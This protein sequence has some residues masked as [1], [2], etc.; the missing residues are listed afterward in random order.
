METPRVSFSKSSP[1]ASGGHIAKV[2]QT[3]HVATV[4][5]LKTL[6]AGLSELVFGRSSQQTN[7][8]TSNH[9]G[10]SY[11]PFVG[12]ETDSIKHMSRFSGDSIENF[13]ASLSETLAKMETIP[14]TQSEFGIMTL[15]P[16]F[17][18]LSI[19]LT[20][21]LYQG[22]QFTAD[23]RTQVAKNLDTKYDG[24]TSELLMSTIIEKL[25]A[26]DFEAIKTLGAQLEAFFSPPPE[27]ETRE[28]LQHSAPPIPR[29]YLG[30]ESTE[31]RFAAEY[32]PH[33]SGPS[34]GSPARIMNGSDVPPPAPSH[35]TQVASGAGNEVM[36]PGLKTIQTLQGQLMAQLK[37]DPT[38]IARAFPKR[39]VTGIDVA[40]A[41]LRF[42]GPNASDVKMWFKSQPPQVQQ[43]IMRGF[44][45]IANELNERRG[46][47]TDSP[48]P[49]QDDVLSG[50]GHG[51]I[52]H[53][54]P[55]SEDNKPPVSWN[56]NS[57][58]TF[59][60]QRIGLG[61]IPN[62]GQ[63]PQGH[64]TLNLDSTRVFID[65]VALNQPN[66]GSETR[67]ESNLHDDSGT[68]IVAS[69][70]QPRVLSREELIAA[71][72]QNND[73]EPGVKMALTDTI[74]A[75]ILPG[76][77]KFQRSLAQNIQR[78]FPAMGPENTRI[79]LS[80]GMAFI[81]SC[82]P[83]PGGL[84]EN[85]PPVESK[86]SKSSL[87]VSEIDHLR[88][89]LATNPAKTKDLLHNLVALRRAHDTVI[90][91]QEPN[92][93]DLDHVMTS[94]QSSCNA[95]KVAL[96]DRAPLTKAEDSTSE[97]PETKLMHDFQ[98]SAETILKC[99][100][101]ANP[102]I[103]GALQIAM[104]Y[105][106]TAS[107]DQL[108]DSSQKDGTKLTFD[109]KTPAMTTIASSEIKETVSLVG[110]EYNRASSTVF[111]ILYDT[112]INTTTIAIQSSAE[113]EFPDRLKGEDIKFTPLIIRS[114]QEAGIKDSAAPISIDS[115]KHWMMTIGTALTS[116]TKDGEHLDP[117]LRAAGLKI[118]SNMSTWQPDATTTKSLDDWV[119]QF[120]T[121]KMNNEDDKSV[122]ERFHNALKK[123][124]LPGSPS[125]VSTNF[126]EVD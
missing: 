89:Q 40:N 96:A 109:R 64:F 71:I 99:L 116:P 35:E 63:P 68:L 118:V 31:P 93:S 92:S 41:A 18:N 9:Q 8:A 84:I 111:S 104:L 88:Q 52:P 66:D 80:M 46:L 74:S 120:K 10:K 98:V 28:H 105:S 1:V 29:P 75:G 102:K 39:P 3:D 112:D 95:V 5:S 103:S 13:K 117:Q 12:T 125:N 67:V 115:A 59:R 36:S 77:S 51:F 38:T 20:E 72:K 44:Q 19:A 50:M 107:L 57:E 100:E 47:L 119:E 70:Q 32:T 65:D 76:N 49:A 123:A 83:T 73:L 82:S 91:R 2:D 27:F 87:A 22:Q 79:S 42:A 30:S 58:F 55:G 81:D 126:D 25:K 14:I 101:T 124:A 21:I 16:E 6:T 48:L 106:V 37:N 62:W 53:A 94:L 4:F 54:A 69:A 56:G 78:Q 43:N 110:N 114:A 121:D 15:N 108:I 33:Q 122:C 7:Q 34:L 45:D 26:S 17:A 60:N 97:D 86:P 11:S 113:L 61:P 23:Q 90:N 24:Q 85:A